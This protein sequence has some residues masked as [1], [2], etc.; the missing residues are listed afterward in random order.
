MCSD[1]TEVSP[2]VIGPFSPSHHETLVRGRIN[3]FE[4]REKGE[5]WVVG[6]FPNKNILHS[7]WWNKS[8][9]KSSKCLLLSSF[10]FDDKKNSCINFCRPNW[11]HWCTTLGEKKKICPRRLPTS[12]LPPPPLLRKIMVRPSLKAINQGQKCPGT[13]LIRNVNVARLTKY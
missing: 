3:L 1:I 8:R 4:Q 13:R 12:Q 6:L 5:G 7:Y 10:G 11:K 2:V 9:T